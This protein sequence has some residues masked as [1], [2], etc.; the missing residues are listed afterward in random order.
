MNMNPTFKAEPHFESEVDL[1][2]EEEEFYDENARLNEVYSPTPNVV[3]HFPRLTS[4]VPTT[5]ALS[6]HTNAYRPTISFHPTNQ[7]MVNIDDLNIP[8]QKID[9]LKSVHDTEKLFVK[10]K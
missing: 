1:T 5:T 7:M 10:G 9:F 8:L 2:L 6:L 3:P 4:N